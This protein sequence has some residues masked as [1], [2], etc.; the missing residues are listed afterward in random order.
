MTSVRWQKVLGEDA[1][2][3]YVSVKR[4]KLECRVEYNGDVEYDGKH[5]AF[6]MQWS[7]IDVATH[8]VLCGDMGHEFMD[9]SL[10]AVKSMKAACEEALQKYL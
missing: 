10:E 1:W 4:K 6:T 3:A 2:V 5:H 8:M 7:I 9:D